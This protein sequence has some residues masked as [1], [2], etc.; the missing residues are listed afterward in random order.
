MSD[1]DAA[2]QVREQDGSWAGWVSNDRPSAEDVYRLLDP[3]YQ[4]PGEVQR[5][6]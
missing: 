3:E 2:G 6:G 1:Y 5:H 4:G